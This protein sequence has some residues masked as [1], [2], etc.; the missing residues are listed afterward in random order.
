MMKYP[1]VRLT[2]AASMSA[3]ARTPAYWIGHDIKQ[4]N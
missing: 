2:Q 1:N 4:P 3:P